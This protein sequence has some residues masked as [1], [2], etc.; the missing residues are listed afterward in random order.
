MS[1]WTIYWPVFAALG[2]ILVVKEAIY[3]VLGLY[4]RRKQEKLQK[5]MEAKIASGEI[6]P[7][8][9]MF[10]GGGGMPGMPGMAPPG[11]EVPQLPTTSGEETKGHGT[12]L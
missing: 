6:N 10:G 2:S 12:Y 7:M 11:S 4:F 5:E 8:E 1:F 3:F 9:M